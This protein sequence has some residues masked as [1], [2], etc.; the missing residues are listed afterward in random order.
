MPSTLG[1][2]ALFDAVTEWRNR[3]P[4]QPLPA[5]ARLSNGLIVQAGPVP[6]RGYVLMLRRDVVR[7]S[8]NAPVA[9]AFSD[10]LGNQVN[11]YNLVFISARNVSP[12]A[13][14][15]PAA[16][17]LCE[18]ADT[19]WLCQ[20]PNYSIPINKSYNVRAPGYGGAY[21]QDTMRQV[22]GQTGT[23]TSAAATVTSLTSTTP[24]SAG[25]YVFGAGVLPAATIQSVDSSTQVTLS[26]NATASGSKALTFYS[27]WTWDKMTGDVWNQHAIQLVSTQSGTL[28][29]ASATVTGL[30]STAG[31]TAGMVV[32]GTG[33]IP[34]TTV[35]SVDSGTQVTLSLTATVAGSQSLSFYTGPLGPYSTAGLPFTP[36]G[37]PEDWQFPG[38]GA[39]NALNQ[40]LW[41]VGCAFARDLRQQ[42]GRQYSIVRIGVQDVPAEVLIAGLDAGGSK[43]FDEEWIESNV[44]REP[45]GVRAF[46]HRK[47]ADY[48][49]E[50]TTPLDSSQWITNAAY[51][52]DVAGP[53]VALTQPGLYAP[54]WD[55][56]PA[57]YSGTVV[58]TLQISGTPTSGSYTI[59][60]VDGGGTTRTTGS[61]AYTATSATVQ[62]ALRALAGLES[63]VVSTSTGT[64]PN[65]THQI[66][67]FGVN[68][69][70]NQI[71]AD[72]TGLAGGSPAKAIATT[73]AQ[74]QNLAALSTRATERST[75][76]FRMLGS[77][78]GSRV[79]K[80]YGRVV[81][82]VTGSEV[83]GV[84]W[85]QSPD[86]SDD[87]GGWFTEIVRHPWRFLKGIDPNDARGGWG[88]Y[89]MGSLALQPRDLRP[90]FPVY[91]PSIHEINLNTGTANANGEFDAWVEKRDP[92]GKTWGDRERV[93]GV[94]INGV[95]TVT[96]QRYL[97][98]GPVGFK[99]GR[100][101]YLFSQDTTGGG[102]ATFSGCRARQSGGQT[103]SD[104]ADT[105]I[106]LNTEYF[107]TDGYHDN[108]T[109]NARLTVPT[110]GYYQ[111]G[112]L[113]GFSTV[114]SGTGKR[115]F[116]I[117]KNGISSG[118]LAAIQ[119]CEGTT[120]ALHSFST[121]ASLSAGEYVLLSAFQDS[122]GSI[123]LGG[124]AD[125]YPVLWITRLGT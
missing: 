3:F 1:G 84:Y 19:T 33:V 63:V 122:G 27:P 62:T 29:V 10:N 18:L 52:V 103:I 47:Q 51:S 57:L 20:N 91:P 69:T 92:F 15:D 9:L 66:T 41:R 81:G 82:F 98:R 54:V 46:F 101:T 107:D 61:I 53:D 89:D 28:A 43:E 112:A 74:I 5:G 72:I 6:S 31:V 12:G 95:A 58:Q 23:L 105:A 125:A 38:T 78:G 109:N 73:A 30:A 13:S 2:F 8:L 16:V 77:F 25:M 71:T 121:I 65:V 14:A 116:T 79:R 24:L 7:L 32:S 59:S 106:T 68:G 76:F 111:I 44:G 40:I 17:Y 86:R 85:G 118:F 34:G 49:T 26:Q 4:G 96:Q 104:S 120:A 56:L 119:W 64:P 117:W 124:F 123:A 42:A 108:V 70:V 99:D 93:W 21:Y 90:T 100:P 67:F 115:Q 113:A 36:D 110:T 114:G 88:E 48:G 87:G 35:A 39:W 83:K 37:T 80:R 45:Y 75:D 94:E 60:W 102:A 50:E 11:F 97:A 22:G 55:D